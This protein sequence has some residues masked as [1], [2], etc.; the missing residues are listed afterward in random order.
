MK[1]RRFIDTATNFHDQ[2]TD[3]VEKNI[4]QR[5]LGLVRHDESI[6]NLAKITRKQIIA[7]LHKNLIQNAKNKC[8]YFGTEM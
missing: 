3:Y 6:T 8:L 7:G 5:Y 4:Y 1:Y 2:D